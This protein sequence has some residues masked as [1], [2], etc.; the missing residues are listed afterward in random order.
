MES[1]ILAFLYLLFIV[2]GFYL[3]MTVIINIIGWIAS[4]LGAFDTD[5]SYTTDDRLNH[6]LSTDRLHYELETKL[7]LEECIH[8][9]VKLTHAQYVDYLL[10]DEWRTRA[11]K[12]LDIDDWTCQY[13]GSE[14]RSMSGDDH[15][16]NVHHLHYRNLT[17]EDIK[18]DLVSLCKHCH[19]ELHSMYSLTDMEFHINVERMKRNS[20]SS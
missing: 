2:A 20:I 3:V 18:N 6:A 15:T 4:K 9:A 5:S 7:P 11:N 17:H 10:T 13:C 14:L 16:P 12:R 8:V 1:F 19:L